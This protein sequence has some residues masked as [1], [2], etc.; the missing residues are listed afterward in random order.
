MNTDERGV[1]LCIV[2][3][4][5]QASE[6]SDLNLYRE[7]ARMRLLV[8]AMTAALIAGY[9]SA[10]TPHRPSSK[11]AATASVP[12]LDTKKAC[13]DTSLGTDACLA[14]EDAARQMLIEKWSSFPARDKSSCY[15]EMRTVDLTLSYIDYVDCLLMFQ[16]ARAPLPPPKQ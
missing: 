4:S 16:H 14:Q 15:N 1:V 6:V 2:A 13:K 8:A 5:L 3:K 9:A 7:G 10:K 11:K 12:N